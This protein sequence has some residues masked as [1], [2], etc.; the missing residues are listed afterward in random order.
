MGKGE[1]GGGGG[2]KEGRRKKKGEREREKWESAL[3]AAG[4]EVGNIQKTLVYW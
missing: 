4:S 2:G 3:P 1:G